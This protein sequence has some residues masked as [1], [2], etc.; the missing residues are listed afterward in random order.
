M[1]WNLRLNWPALV[2]EARRRRKAQRL[3]QQRL[4]AI[5]DVSAPTV[6]RFESGEKNI[7]LASVLAIL[8]ALGMTERSPIDFPDKTETFDSTRD[9]VLFPARTA[10][11]EITCA[12]SGEALEDR[13]GARGAS[14][15]ARLAAFRHQR[16]KIEDAARRKFVARQLEPDGSILI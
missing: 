2:E 3:T 14:Q 15:R 6:S 1:E 10:S 13:F 11:G 5:A 16:S 12:V 8:E 9:V 7:Q 4:A